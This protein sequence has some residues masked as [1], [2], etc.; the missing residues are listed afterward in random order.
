[1]CKIVSKSEQNSRNKSKAYNE[2][3]VAAVAVQLTE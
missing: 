2:V 1:M 3:A